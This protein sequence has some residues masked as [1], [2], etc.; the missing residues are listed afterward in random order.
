MLGG[1]INFKKVKERNKEECKVYELS[2]YILSVVSIKNYKVN[3][4]ELKN[5]IFQVYDKYYKEYGKELIN[6][7]YIELYRYGVSI[8]PITHKYKDKDLWYIEEDV[9]YSIE[10][11]KECGK[12]YKIVSNIVEL[13]TQL[14]YIDL[15]LKS[16]SKYKD[17]K[18]LIV[19]D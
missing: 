2:D 13:N 5:L 18:H 8:T 10:E 6:Q 9:R 1:L 16:K 14:T 4:L 11:L 7:E 17:Y 19:Y 15:L 12:L 3:K